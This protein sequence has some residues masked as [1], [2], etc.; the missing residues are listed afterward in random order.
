MNIVQASIKPRRYIGQTPVRHAW[1]RQHGW[2][3]APHDVNVKMTA[4]SDETEDVSGDDH[5]GEAPKDFAGQWPKGA[6]AQMA[7]FDRL[8]VLQ[9][10]DKLRTALT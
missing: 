7:S 1:S 3:G 8:T 2:Q 9:P 10:G 5:V 6:D 4:L